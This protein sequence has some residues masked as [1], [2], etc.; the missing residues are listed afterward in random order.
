MSL[1]T[2]SIT[3]DMEYIRILLGKD[4]VIMI[5]LLLC[6]CSCNFNYSKPAGTWL[7]EFKMNAE[8]DSVM[9]TVYSYIDENHTSRLSM[10]LMKFDS[11][12]RIDIVLHSEDY[13]SKYIYFRNARVLG[14]T[15]I[16]SDTAIILSNIEFLPDVEESFS[17]YLRPTGNTK[18]FEY[19]DMTPMLLGGKQKH[20]NDNGWVFSEYMYMYEPIYLP[21][22]IENERIVFKNC[23]RY[24]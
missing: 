5:I 10:E 17:R 1:V 13:L 3:M 12:R 7:E 2:L 14:F 4:K 11:V 24:R 8:M 6:F 18:Y 23:Y 19:I 21:C 15:K 16:E 20:M 22:Y 9:K